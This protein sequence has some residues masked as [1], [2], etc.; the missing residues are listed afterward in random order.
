MNH[1]AIKDSYFLYADGQLD[2]RQRAE[3][4]LHLNGCEECRRAYRRSGEVLEALEAIAIVEHE[5]HPSLS[6]LVANEIERRGAAKLFSFERLRWFAL[7]ATTIVMLLLMRSIFTANAPASGG[8]SGGG[9]SFSE[10]A[11]DDTLV[12]SSVGNL[13][14]LLEGTVGAI[15]MFACLALGCVGVFV[16]RHTTRTWPFRLALCSIGFGLVLVGLRWIVGLMF[17]MEP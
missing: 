8:S 9:G 6:V 17:G 4:D 12:R 5:P 7:G 3:I 13:F 1:E 11:Y 14:Q 2:D 16:F 10:A 15:V